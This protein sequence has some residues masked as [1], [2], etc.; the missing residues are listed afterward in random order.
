MENLKSIFDLPT[1]STEFIPHRDTMLLIDELQEY[2]EGKIK[3]TAK[4][5]KDNPFLD[6]TGTLSRNCLV[7]IMAQVVAAGNGYDARLKGDTLR[8]GFLVGVNDFSFYEDVK[9]DDELTVTTFEESNFGDFSIVEGSINI[10]NRLIAKGNLKLY[11][12]KGEP[13]KPAGW[14][15][16]EVNNETTVGTGIPLNKKSLFFSAISESSINVNMSD[17]RETILSEFF[18]KDDFLG[19]NGHFPNFPILPGVVMMETVMV[20]AETLCGKTLKIANI[21]KAKFSKQSYPGELLKGEVTMAFA[22]NLWHINAK[23]SCNGSPV[24]SILINAN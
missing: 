2:C 5:K 22:G 11:E 3:G 9:V 7:E 6:N 18:F 4:I 12:I 21:A 13:A 10:E 14:E 20:L 16:T 23:L 19:F 15:P 1:K 24:S 17:D 8:T